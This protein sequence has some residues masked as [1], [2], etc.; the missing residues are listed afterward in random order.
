[1]DSR[2]S[3]QPDDGEAAQPGAAGPDQPKDRHI[4]VDKRQVERARRSL[5]REELRQE[6]PGQWL[7]NRLLRST[8]VLTVLLVLGGGKFPRMPLAI[9]V[10][11]V[12]AALGISC[13]LIGG[14]LTSRGR[15]TWLR[16][17]KEE[18]GLLIAGWLTLLIWVWATFGFAG[19]S[20]LLYIHGIA[21]TAPQH[22]IDDPIGGPAV[23]FYVWKSLDAIPVLQIPQTAGW[24]PAFRFT[25]HINPILLLLYKVI[26][27]TPV[28]ETGRLIW[29]SRRDHTSA[30]RTASDQSESSPR[31]AQEEEPD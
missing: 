7:R 12:V 5:K 22:A 31:N 27:I 1:V 14:L 15:D 13:F 25:D 10:I 19:L 26:V 17:V 28:I 30:P 20:G 9:Q 2:Q 23:N 24:E 3:A 16:V 6:Y 18:G 29:K 8:G 21:T 4:P 11:L